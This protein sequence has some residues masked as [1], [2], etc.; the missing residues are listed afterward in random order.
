[1]A[2]ACGSGSAVP[3]PLSVAR[4]PPAALPKWL[5]SARATHLVVSFLNGAHTFVQLVSA[6]RFLGLLLD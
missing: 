6:D 1:V 3:M 4:R 2:D 5:S